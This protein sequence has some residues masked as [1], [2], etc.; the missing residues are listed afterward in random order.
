LQELW[1]MDADR[2]RAASNGPQIVADD[3]PDEDCLACEWWI[4]R[5]FEPEE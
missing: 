2:D 1:L 3:W 4:Q 5:Y